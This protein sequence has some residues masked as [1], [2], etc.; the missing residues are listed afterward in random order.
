MPCQHD[1]WYPIS[2]EHIKCERCWDCGKTRKIKMNECK[3]CKQ[4]WK[5]PRNILYK[6]GM[7]LVCY[8][9]INNDKNDKEQTTMNKWM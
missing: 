8:Y 4:S 9:I 1:E 3:I 6:D 2:I 5:L 7:C